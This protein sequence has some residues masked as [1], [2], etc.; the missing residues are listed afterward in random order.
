MEKEIP[1]RIGINGQCQYEWSTNIREQ[2]VQYYYQLVRPEP[3]NQYKYD[4]LEAQYFILVSSIILNN[5]D[6]KHN[7]RMSKG[8]QRECLMM[9]YKMIAQTRDILMGKGEYKL[10]YIMIAVLSYMNVSYDGLSTINMAKHALRSF[11]L[12]IPS[13][14][15]HNNN[16]NSRSY[17]SWKDIKY[18]CNYCKKIGMVETH[19][20]IR[21]AIQLMTTQL[22]KD[23]QL[24]ENNKSTTSLSLVSKWIPREKSKKF[25]WLYPYLVQSYYNLKKAPTYQNNKYLKKF[26]KI[27]TKMNKQLQT[28]QIVQTKRQYDKIN[29]KH[30]TSQTF[31]KQYNAFI[32]YG[33]LTPTSSSP[34]PSPIHTHGLSEHISM[35]EFVRIASKETDPYRIQLLD[36]LWATQSSIKNPYKSTNRYI[37]PIVD[38]SIH[39]QDHSN[40]PLYTAIGLAIRVSELSLLKNRILLFSQVPKWV[41]IPAKDNNRF[42]AKVKTILKIIKEDNTMNM[43]SNIFLATNKLLQGYID[44]KIPPNRVKQMTWM[45]FSNMQHV[46]DNTLPY[47][48][49][50]QHSHPP[51]HPHPH[52]QHQPPPPTRK[53]FVFESI[54]EKIKKTFYEAGRLSDYRTPFEPSHIV[55]WN[56]TSNL[57]FPCKSTTPN[58][59]MVSG[60]TPTTINQFR[61]PHQHHPSPHHSPSKKPLTPKRTPWDALKYTLD[62]PRYNPMGQLL[63][64]AWDAYDIINDE[65]KKQL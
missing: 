49:E 16:N 32:K 11:V 21:Y 42:S 8:G 40:H 30:V 62:H 28:I 53:Q 26:R 65:N 43:N 25:G 37:L 54:Y 58:T 9:A 18:F 41:N 57:G 38:T 48:S 61:I 20:M 10:S 56:L 51:P 35:Y 34:S 64:D 6:T 12:N 4:Y 39:M 52:P 22:R 24:Y 47:S 1:S 63:I 3:D 17:G 59:T 55:F 31:A 2:L 44:S 45:F 19:P 5:G 60:Y 33:I 36:H 15:H 13:P 50:K 29:I 46:D 23:V 7:P 27:L 14:T